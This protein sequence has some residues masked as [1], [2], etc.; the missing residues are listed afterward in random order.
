M[1]IA[2]IILNRAVRDF[3][4]VETKNTKIA[5]DRIS[6]YRLAFFLTTITVVSYKYIIL[7]Y[8]TLI[9]ISA[10]GLLFS[11]KTIRSDAQQVVTA[12]GQ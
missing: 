9:R 8:Y 11:N 5:E 2:I 7:Y 12:H 10:S 4:R 1:L 3:S 6:R